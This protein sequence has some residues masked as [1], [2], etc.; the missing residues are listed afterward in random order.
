[1][2]ASGL[3]VRCNVFPNLVEYSAL[4]AAGA[5]LVVIASC[6]R[7]YYRPQRS[8]EITTSVPVQ[9]KKAA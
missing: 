8:E 2:R 4:V 6:W 1:M 7:E 3:Q 5:A 9:Q